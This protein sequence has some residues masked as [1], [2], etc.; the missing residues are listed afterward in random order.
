[1]SSSEFPHP[2][3]A[4]GASTMPSEEDK[5]RFR[6]ELVFLIIQ[7]LRGEKFEETIHMLEQESALYFDMKHF[8]KMVVAGNWDELERYLLG[9]TR[10]EDNEQSMKI[11]FLIRRQKYLE[12]LESSTFISDFRENEE[13]KDCGDTKSM[14]ALLL[15][16]LKKLI[17]M[18]PL[19]LGKL[20]FPRIKKSRLKALISQSSKICKQTNSQ[21]PM[22]EAD[23]TTNFLDCVG[24]LPTP[25]ALNTTPT[26]GVA[27]SKFRAT[28][29]SN[30][31]MDPCSV[32]TTRALTWTRSILISESAQLRIESSTSRDK[33]CID[34]LPTYV[35]ATLRQGYTVTS[36]DF[37]P[38]QHTVL[39]GWVPFARACF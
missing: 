14:R 15:L 23:G 6:K 24:E 7:F 35:A 16:E 18:N 30:P 31:N 28:T 3:R 12:A 13:F 9:F 33:Q 8:V 37:H 19:F 11:F 21:N 1:M 29:R 36:I 34:D 17:M 38:S 27:S 20:Q 2:A 26:H 22:P 32:N 25:A 5:R 10:L 39:L 4:G